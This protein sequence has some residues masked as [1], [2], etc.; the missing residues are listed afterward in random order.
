MNRG[1]LR[2]AAPNGEWSEQMESASDL[3]QHDQALRWATVPS[4][5]FERFEEAVTAN[6]Q[7]LAQAFLTLTNS[8]LACAFACVR[9]FCFSKTRAPLHQDR[10]VCEPNR[11]PPFDVACGCCHVRWAHRNT[12]DRDADWLE[13]V[14]RVFQMQRRGVGW[15]AGASSVCTSFGG[16]GGVAL[17]SRASHR[18]LVREVQHIGESA[19]RDDS[20]VRD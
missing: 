18:R 16:V 20:S 14:I 17:A 3:S 1:E 9:R 11:L 19:T 10:R 2:Y 13:F 5:L 7:H 15:L 6:R 8:K 4:D 12:P